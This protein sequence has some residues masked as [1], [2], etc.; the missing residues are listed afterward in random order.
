GTD[1]HDPILSP[2]YADLKGMPPTLFLTSTRDLL[3]SGTVRLHKAYLHAGVDAQIVVWDAL[4]HAFWN[5]YKMPEAIEAH[6]LM[7]D[8]FDRH[9]R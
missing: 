1:P 2:L 3:L 4:P 6:H 8:F 9:L 7:A 5:E